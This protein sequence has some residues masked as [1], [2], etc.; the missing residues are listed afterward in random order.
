MGVKVIVRHGMVTVMVLEVVV[1]TMAT[2]VMGDCEN[3]N[4]DTCMHTHTY[5]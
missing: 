5:A 2:K 4:G 3:V 1:T